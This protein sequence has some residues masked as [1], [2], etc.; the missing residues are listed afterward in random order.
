MVPNTFEE[1]SV[2]FLLS[3]LLR[4]YCGNDDIFW[5]SWIVGRDGRKPLQISGELLA[6][7][8]TSS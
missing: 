8:K 7:V 3:E 1:R 2:I 6:P 5:N 4:L